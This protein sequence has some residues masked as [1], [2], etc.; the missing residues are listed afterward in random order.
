MHMLRRMLG[1][2]EHS[3]VPFHRVVDAVVVGRDSS[4]SPVFQ[5][6]LVMQDGMQEA[7]EGPRGSASE[8][9][10]ETGSMESDDGGNDGGAEGTR[11]S[12]SLIVSILEVVPV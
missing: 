1:A 5:A 6:M 4:Q 7:G 10:K 12:E 3:D 11:L 9:S 2:F 8:E